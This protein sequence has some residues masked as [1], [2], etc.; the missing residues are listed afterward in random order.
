MRSAAPRKNGRKQCYGRTR[1]FCAFTLIELLVVIAII[2]ILAAMLLP[3]LSRAK[4]RAR[5]ISC[6]N[7]SRQV[8]LAFL[9]YAADNSERLPSLNKGYWPGVIPNAW[10]FNILD[11][12]KYVPPTA[13]S[14]H[15]WRCPAVADGDILQA[16]TDYYGVAWEGYGPLEGNT[17]TAGIIRY[18]IQSDGVTLMGSRKLTEL[19]RPSQLWL[20]GD[21][22]VPKLGRFPDSL[23]VGGYYTEITTKTPDTA[24]GWTRVL[25]QPACRHV[26]RAV[27]TFCDGH[28][29]AW[30]FQD[31]R[32]DKSDVFAITS[33]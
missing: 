24:V 25:K 22:G 28:T 32:G 29:E 8:G 14:N 19:I 1:R 12:G 26:K 13:I 15:I 10:W 20:M 21:V 5:S 4:D 11:E 33:F 23:P 2:A 18:A 3:A 30:S 6:N 7:N 16:V 17:D 31:L 27:V 9:M